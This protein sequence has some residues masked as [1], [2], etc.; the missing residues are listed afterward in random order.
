MTIFSETYDAVIELTEVNRE[1]AEQ[2][3]PNF[4]VYYLDSENQEIKCRCWH[5]A[6]GTAYHQFPESNQYWLKSDSK[7]FAR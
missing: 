3:F 2:A 4:A 6:V 7:F 1:Q 5:D